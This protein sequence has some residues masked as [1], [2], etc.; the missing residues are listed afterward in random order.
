M[1]GVRGVLFS[2]S[3][4]VLAGICAVAGLQLPAVAAS[5]GL[6]AAAVS[7]GSVPVVSAAPDEA[8]L[9]PELSTETST[10]YR[11][12]NG[13]YSMDV[14]ASVV[15]Y[16]DD[17]GVWHQVD[18]DLVEAKGAAFAVKNGAAAHTV[19]I[20]ED[21]GSTPVKISADGAWVSMH[22]RGLD[23]A[24]QVQGDTAT[25]EQV[26]VADEV[27]YQATGEGVKES[28]V[29]AEAP[30]GEGPVVFRYDLAASAGLSPRLSEFSTVEFVAE[31]GSVPFVV[32]A[33]NMSDA[34]S[35]YSEAVSFDLSAQGEGWV[36]TMT[37][38]AS[39]LRDPAREYPVVIDPGFKYDP[40]PQVDCLLR[41][42]NAN[43]IW[44][45]ATTL[46][47]G[48]DGAGKKHRSVLRFDMSA[49]PDGI[50]IY[51]ANLELWLTGAKYSNPNRP[52]DYAVYATGKNFWSGVT[53]NSTGNNGP[54]VNGGGDP[55]N[56]TQSPVN[57]L[58][59]GSA[60]GWR[61]WE[62]KD[63]VQD[64]YADPTN[65]TGFVIKQ[66]PEGQAENYVYFASGEY[67]QT[68]RRPILNVLYWKGP[69]VNAS[70]PNCVDAGDSD[71]T[72]KV[73][74]TNP[75]DQ[76]GTV[77]V[78]F[79]SKATQSVTLAA[80]QS[81]T[82][83]FTGVAAGGPYNGTASFPNGFS[84][85]SSTY[86]V[87]VDSCA[88]RTPGP[89]AADAGDRPFWTFNDTELT[90]RLTAKV[91]VGTG[92]LLVQAQDSSVAGV[93]GWDMAMTRYYNSANA[94]GSGNTVGNMGPGWSTGFGDSVRLEPTGAS[95][96]MFFFGPSA[97]RAKF[98]K[99]ADGS[100][101]RTKPGIKADLREESDGSYTLTWYDKGKYT[102]DSNGRLQ[103]TK[104][105]NGNELT[106]NY[107]AGGKLA[108]VVDTRGRTALF[109]YNAQGLV[110]QVE[111]RKPDNTV[112][113]RWA[114]GYSNGLLTSSELDYVDDTAVGGTYAN[115]GSDP[116]IGAATTYTYNA[117][118]YLASITDAR[119]NATGNGGVTQF[120]YDAQMRLATQTRVASSGSNSVT[121]FAYYS[122]TNS[123][124]CKNNGDVVDQDAN[125]HT[126]VDGERLSSDVKD[127]TKYCT[128]DVGR[129]LRTT[130]ARGNKRS[131]TWDDQS[132]I[133]TA[134]MSGV[135]AGTENYEFSYDGKDN[136]RQSQS[137]ESAVAEASYLD[138]V[139]DHSPTQV[140]DDYSGGGSTPQ[141]SWDYAY[142]DKNNLIK[143]ASVGGNLE[144]RYQ[145]C[146]TGDGQILRIDPVTQTGTATNSTDPKRDTSDP[147]R[148]GGDAAQG[149]DTLFT[150]NADGELIDVDRPDGGDV[151]MTY[152][153]LSRLATVTDGRGVL[154]SYEYDGLDRIVKAVYSKSG[155]PTQTVNWTYDLAGNLTSLG[156]ANGTNTFDYD[157]LNRKISEDDGT[158]TGP[159]ASTDYTYDP[160]GNLRT[161]LEHVNGAAVDYETSYEFN[162]VNMVTQVDYVATLTGTSTPA[163]TSRR[164]TMGYDKKDNR[165]QTTW[166]GQNGQ[167]NIVHEARYDKDG[168]TT[169]VY[170]FKSTNA[171]G[172][173]ADACPSPTGAQGEK[174]ITYYGYDYKNAS[175]A[176]TELKWAM[177]ELGGKHTAYDYDTIQRLESAVTRPSQGAGSSLRRFDYDY[178]RHSNLIKEQVTG[179]NPTPGLRLGTQW[180]AFSPGDEL[181]ATA[182]GGTDPGVSCSSSVSGQTSFTHDAAGNL[183]TATGGTSQDLDGLGLVY[184]L[185]G[186]TTS[187]T[188][189]GGGNAVAQA[190]DGV[191]QDRRTTSGSTQMAYG[192]A[193][194][195]NQTTPLGTGNAAHGEWFVRDPEGKVL[196]MV[197]VTNPTAPS[198]AGY[199]LL[200]DQDS[201]M[202]IINPAATSATRYL[203]EPYGETIRTWTDPNPGTSTS[204]YTEDGTA[205]TPVDDYNP[206][207]YVS[208]YH[209]KTTGFLKF[210]TRYYM[211]AHA[212]WTQ[213]DPKNGSPRRPL[214]MNRYNY[215]GCS[216][217]N[218]A[219]PSGR[220]WAEVGGAA[221]MLSVCAGGAVSGLGAAASPPV[222]GAANLFFGPYGAIGAALILPIAGCVGAM[223]ATYLSLDF[224]GLL[225]MPW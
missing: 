18:N 117:Q 84:G 170:S 76:S 73:N 86:S 120:G 218:A 196:S 66:A 82:V 72:V 94:V 88:I 7:A 106:Y 152:D 214:T 108:T 154:T 70:A 6:S 156:D 56:S 35:A 68:T 103:A 177:T 121:S 8:V 113:V 138:T 202:A 89:T 223:T 203:Y 31:D 217:V 146:W 59:G 139:N 197:D 105:K 180:A 43:S 20:P 163:M 216:P 111:V 153:K 1:M 38:D 61:Y 22:L 47:A 25:F 199:Y 136:P 161:V 128:D 3:T 34:G 15:N 188:P 53:W 60:P 74:V 175:G 171:P 191:E 29:L 79:P 164:I 184:N 124:A 98:V 63:I 131:N 50:G 27:S 151:T 80:N 195:T 28:V 24:P 219:D 2:S 119:K 32:P 206:W 69:G 57:N 21:G 23:G 189:P 99:N 179:D 126:R 91:N 200:D 192:F 96:D 11:L 183:T 4:A 167:P 165:T 107:G 101:S 190:Y 71:G 155:Q 122:G 77:D 33:G 123:A 224:E 162:A 168:D 144:V 45:G 174:L 194:L 65:K 173:G 145:Y 44:C 41:E 97:Y 114:Y 133:A 160:A 141:A 132:N 176:R 198:V 147:N 62:V 112:M 16:Q 185:P 92:N 127:V 172:N 118:N 159:V 149:N 125:N 150:Y 104:D 148:C 201:V 40:N 100:F 14:G 208:G 205:T 225:D 64:W 83:T 90:D 157:A 19:K 186:Q 5:P 42:E 49:L 26:E 17:A 143:A 110:S 209:D 36:L 182:R 181:C 207:R 95:G 39:W 93:A 115:P 46:E 187:V 215:S 193:G 55:V 87:I 48:R 142:D 81:Q 67:G 211:P 129:V 212:T 137:P 52:A 134:D 116:T 13:L 75:N 130:D 109:S 140:R 221:A 213:P 204:K 10:T 166:I 58:G 220:S 222:V 51:H 158:L 85:A 54:W 102:F 210:G 169:C 12:P 37:P 178:D 78:T 30:A 9:V 135:G